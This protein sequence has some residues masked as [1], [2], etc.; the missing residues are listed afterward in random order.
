MESFCC[1]IADWNLPEKSSSQVF[2]N[3]FCDTFQSSYVEG[4]AYKTKS[5]SKKSLDQLYQKRDF[6]T[7]TQLIS[8]QFLI[9]EIMNTTF[10]GTLMQIWKSLYMFVFI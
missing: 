5:E 4:I 6:C 10:K 8:Y 7:G 1:K 2:S 3:D 9:K